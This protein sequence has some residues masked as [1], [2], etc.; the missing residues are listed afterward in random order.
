MKHPQFLATGM[1]NFLMVVATKT[2]ARTPDAKTPTPGDRSGSHHWL[3][4]LYGWVHSI[5]GESSS[6]FLTG[7]G[8]LSE[9]MAGQPISRASSH[10]IRSLGSRL[11]GLARRP[12]TRLSALLIGS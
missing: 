2:A 8:V 5:F 6:K 1:L 10:Y 9:A 12:V 7:R 3:I 11:V 4:G